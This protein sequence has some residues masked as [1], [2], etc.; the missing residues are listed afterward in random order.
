ME[1]SKFS[2][3]RP[4]SAANNHYSKR[5]QQPLFIPPGQVAFRVLCHASRVGGLIGKS[6]SI[7][8]NIQQQTNTKIRVDETPNSATDFRVISVIGSPVVASK[9]KVFVASEVVVVGEEG[10]GESDSGWF[11]VSAAQ[12][13]VLRVFERVV[14]VAAEGDAEAA[15]GGVVSLRILAGKGQVGAVIGKGGMVVE[16]IRRDTGC[17]IK[18][19]LS[20]KLPSGP[21]PNEEIVEVSGEY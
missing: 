19:L 11:D 4:T 2:P 8:K 5:P 6:G 13:G 16:K 12:D 1:S 17:R 20:E 14:E 18:V 9:I 15:I 3:Y 21:F 7:I 10:G